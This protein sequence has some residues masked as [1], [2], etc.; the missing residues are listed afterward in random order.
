MR[1]SK[2]RAPMP[3]RFEPLAVYNAECSRGLMHT[4]EYRE[5]M[6]KLQDEFRE[7]NRSRLIAD[8]FVEVESDLWLKK[9]QLPLRTTLAR[10][11]PRHADQP[12]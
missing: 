6:A 1:R 9:T 3:A 12:E 7:W 11:G 2:R 4:D 10:S 5:R 8:G